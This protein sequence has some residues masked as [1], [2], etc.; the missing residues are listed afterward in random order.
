MT[1]KYY[2]VDRIN[3]LIHCY[4]TDGHWRLYRECEENNFKDV[5]IG[6]SKE[7]YGLKE[8]LTT[9]NQSVGFAKDDKWV[10]SITD[11]MVYA[12]LQWDDVADSWDVVGKV[13]ADGFYEACREFGVDP[14]NQ[15]KGISVIPYSDVYRYEVA[16]AVD[17]FPLGVGAVNIPESGIQVSGSAT[18]E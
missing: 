10:R 15:G 16:D 13:L 17:N 4:C 14:D 7:V 11:R 2:L 3:G 8:S 18:S 9:Y 12:K 5:Q 1:D 6:N